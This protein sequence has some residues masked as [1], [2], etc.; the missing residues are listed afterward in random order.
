MPAWRNAKP[1]PTSEG[2]RV[3]DF[4]QLLDRSISGASVGLVDW[5]GVV[6]VH[7]GRWLGYT[8]VMQVW[9]RPFQAAET[10]YP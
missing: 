2:C 10:H 6:R 7:P 1:D 3:R 4:I 8:E 5:L 9:R